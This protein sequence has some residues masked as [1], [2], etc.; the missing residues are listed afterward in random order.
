LTIGVMVQREARGR[1]SQVSILNDAKLGIELQQMPVQEGPNRVLTARFF[2]NKVVVYGKKILNE[3]LN[4]FSSGFLVGDSA[5]PIRYSIPYFGLIT[6]AE[7]IMLMVGLV[8]WGGKKEIGWWW[9]MLFLAPI[10]AAITIEDTPNMHRALFMVPFLVG[11]E[12]YGLE[13]IW[14]TRKWGKI[15]TGIVL[16]GWILNLVYFGHMYFIHGQFGLASY[17]RDGGNVELAGEINKIQNNYDRIILSNYP[18]NLYPWIAFLNNKDPGSFNLS[19]KNNRLEE[20]SFENLIFSDQH[21]PSEKLIN[22]GLPAGKLLIVDAEGCQIDKIVR[23]KLGLNLI[24]TI[25]RPDNSP[26]YY[27]WEREVTVTE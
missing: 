26:P 4:Y 12:A 6:Y 22:H 16:G 27:L 13:M 5:K 10:P 9:L 11:V 1:L 7:I 17:F 20:S 2:H 14:K 25:R 8:A 23:Q 24:K 21:C 3:Y 19:L 18:D 15:L